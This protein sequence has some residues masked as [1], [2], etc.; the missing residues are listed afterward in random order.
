VAVDAAG[1]ILTADQSDS[2]VRM[3]AARPGTYF[4]R[5]MAAGDIYTIAGNGNVAYSGDGGPATA[6]G[7][8]D[9]ALTADRP[10]NLLIADDQNNR[11]RVVA[12]KT[13]TYYG[14]H[15]TAGDIYTIAGTGSP[16]YSGDGAPGVAT[17][18]SP[19]GAVAD[20]AGNVLITDPWNHRVLLLA[21][22]TGTAYGR[23]V[24]AG[25][26]YT[27]AGNGQDGYSGDGGPARAAEVGS[28]YYPKFGPAGL[29]FSDGPGVRL[30]ADRAGSFYGKRLKAG[31]IY[32]I[33]RPDTLDMAVTSTGDILLAA[34][35]RVLSLAR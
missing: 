26:M 34:F 32:T 31:D 5:H 24:T 13:G 19:T 33:A 22:K 7:L 30:I 3:I 8:F 17:A 29:V 20:P 6:A 25:D 18:C 21:A 28:V 2:R 23:H 11:L 9:T 27:I 14:R 15:M 1:D 10:G 35:D 4:G 12:A 16:T